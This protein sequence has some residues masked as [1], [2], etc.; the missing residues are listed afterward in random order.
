MCEACPSAGKAPARYKSNEYGAS[1]GTEV[2]TCSRLLH[3]A[4]SDDHKGSPRA[5]IGV[6]N[7][8][9]FSMN[10]SM[11]CRSASLPVRFS[12]CLQQREQRGQQ[13]NRTWRAAADVQVNRDDVLDRADH[14][15]A[16]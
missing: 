12:H 11:A 8:L 14:G 2:E 4:Q 5:G 3:R 6:I 10:S 9:G 1:C 16:A 15:I 7:T 13:A